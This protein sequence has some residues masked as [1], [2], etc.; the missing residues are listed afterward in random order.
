MARRKF[1]P[2]QANRTLPLVR[3]IVADLL[4]RGQ[5][6]DR[7]S[8]EQ[9]APDTLRQ[10]ELVNDELRA[11][12]EELEEIGCLFKDWNFRTGL[13]DFP[14]EIDGEEVLLCWRS[15]EERVEWYHTYDEGY[16]GRRRIPG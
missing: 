4:R 2:E 11:L 9:E 10:M 8:K 3:R 15:D 6:L 5:Q 13:V 14:A 7:L 16:P 12:A 1:T